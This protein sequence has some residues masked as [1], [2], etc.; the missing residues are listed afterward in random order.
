MQ[1]WLVRPGAAEPGEVF[2]NQ[3]R[4]FIV[5]TRAGLTFALLL[6]L[7]FVGATNYNLSI[8]FGFTF[9]LASCALVDM[10]LTFRNLAYLTLRPGRAAPVF[11]GEPAHFEIHLVNPRKYDRHALWLAFAE[12]ADVTPE[13]AVD[14]PAKGSAQVMLALA[15]QQRGWLAAPRIRLHTRF[16]LG[17]LRAWSYWRP[18]LRALVYPAPEMQAPPLP[19][20]AAGEDSPAGGTGQED[21]S[22]IRAYRAGDAPRLLAWRQI[23]RLDSD[24]GGPLLSKQF[25]DDSSGSE[26]CIDFTVL[27]ASMALEHKLSRMTRWVLDAE[28]RGLP[29]ALRLGPLFLPAALGPAHQAACLG[30]LALYEGPP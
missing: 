17:F 18:D 25:D 19:L 11:C 28:T 16:P 22:G 5:P 7:L 3:R 24:D 20:R 4:V 14:V 6:L 30:A 2:L 27:P 23:A 12:P 8:G 21:F 1:R 10:H 9:L 29:Y 26:L 13:Q 15:T